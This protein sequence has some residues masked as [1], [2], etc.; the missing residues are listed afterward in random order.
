MSY[1][2]L[3]QPPAFA[4]IE[5]AYRWMCD[6]QSA[7]AANQ[8]YYELQDAIASLQQFPYRCSVAPEAAI[9]DREIRQLWVGKRKTYRILFVVQGDTVALLHIRHRRQAPLDNDFSDSE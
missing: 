1:Q 6:Y 7:D 2:V 4:D 9:L 8:W 3:I 5:T